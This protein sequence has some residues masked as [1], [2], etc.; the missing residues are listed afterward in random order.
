LIRLFPTRENYGAAA[1]CQ[2]Q[3]PWNQ[4]RLKRCYF[5]NSLLEWGMNFLSRQEQLM[6]CIVIGLLLAAWAFE[7]YRA[8]HP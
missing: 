7:A 5:G 1:A 4:R 8:A 2:T 3:T 6:L